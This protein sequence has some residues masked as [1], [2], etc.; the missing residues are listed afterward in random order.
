M[1]STY[2]TRNADDPWRGRQPRYL[3]L[4]VPE[5]GRYALVTT[6]PCGEQIEVPLGRATSPESRSVCTD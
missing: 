5:P 3:R 4:V 1:R 2:G 6:L